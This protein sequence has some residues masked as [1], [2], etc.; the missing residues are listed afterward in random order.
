MRTRDAVCIH[1]G[2]TTMAAKGYW[3]ARLDVSDPE[4]YKDYQA[5]V[6]KIMAE[7]SGRFVVRGGRSEAVEGTARSR[8]VVV[9]F[10]DYETALRCYQ[11]PEYQDAKRLR[12]SVAE[13]DFVVVEGFDGPQ[14]P[15]A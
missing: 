6:R 14:T 2:G 11:L 7:H 8:I 3:V 9:E 5:A 12:Q 13:G 4:R 15:G 10:P 1:L